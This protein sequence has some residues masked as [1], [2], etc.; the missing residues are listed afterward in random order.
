MK[1]PEDNK[2]LELAVNG[3]ANVIVSG[4]ADLLALHPF[5]GIPIEAPAKFMI[6]V[7]GR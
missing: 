5:R 3:N 4:D 1:D 6:R 2:F 7:R